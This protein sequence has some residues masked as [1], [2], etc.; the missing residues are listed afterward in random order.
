MAKNNNFLTYV[1]IIVLIMTIIYAYMY[2]T[3]PHLKEH[4]ENIPVDKNDQKTCDKLK[5][6]YKKNQ[7]EERQISTELENKRNELKKE[8]DAK[9]Q[10][11][12]ETSL[13]E[14]DL[15]KKTAIYAKFQSEL[16]A[17]KSYHKNLE[18][19]YIKSGKDLALM[20]E[21]HSI[22]RAKC[23]SMETEYTK[24]KRDYEAS[25]KEKLASEIIEE[26]LKKQL[27]LIDTK[28]DPMAKVIQTTL[29][30]RQEQKKVIDMKLA[31]EA[32][33][34]KLEYDTMSNLKIK[35]SKDEDAFTKL[36]KQRDVIERQMVQLDTKINRDSKQKSV[37][38]NEL[39]QMKKTI[40]VRDVLNKDLQNDINKLRLN[41]DNDNKIHIK[42][43]SELSRLKAENI[44]T[45]T[46]ITDMK[47]KINKFKIEQANQKDCK[48]V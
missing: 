48:N 17:L 19:D 15:E 41:Y 21:S 30:E 46:M 4:F 40:E 7:A 11:L 45:N 25:L 39:K 38:E 22:E 2:F 8:Q 12:N 34:L 3:L 44:A 32:T 20:R 5:Q 31:E 42:N 43:S 36:K 37:Y 35:L 33:K 27:S 9:D 47:N 6:E 1:V 24:L 28:N 10:T 29:D 13:F 23:T 16:D 26:Q 14:Y 18:K